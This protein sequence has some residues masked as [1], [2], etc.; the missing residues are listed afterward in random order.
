MADLLTPNYGWTLPQVGSDA[1]VWGTTLN[2]D[3]NL[4]DAQVFSNEGAG[5]G[6]GFVTMFAGATPPT[7]W[8]LCNGASYNTSTYAALFAV[9]GYTYG[10][11]GVNFNVPNL[12]ARFALGAG[13]TGGIAVGAVGGASSQTLLATNLP[14]HSHTITDVQH[15]HGITQTAHTHPDGTHSH[16]ATGSQD[17]HNHTIPGSVGF[18][19]GPNTP[20]SPIM[21]EGATPTSTAQPNVYVNVAASGANI[22]AANANLSVNAAGTGL[23]T[24]NATGGSPP[25]P[26]ATMPPFIGIN[27]I[28][29]AV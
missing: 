7:N 18:G 29:R 2:D 27:F 28:I 8:L 19:I 15:S 12:Q 5:V 9:L 4:I 17:P 3:L 14:S 13:G 22:G 10:G 26:V 20:P 23:A 25:T 6:V 11:S 1:S 16:A 24:T 21:N